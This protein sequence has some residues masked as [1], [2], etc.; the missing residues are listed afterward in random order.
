MKP[1]YKNHLFATPHVNGELNIALLVVLFTRTTTWH[2]VL[3]FLTFTP[4]TE[5][6]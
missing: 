2:D 1:R 6:L 4:E 5:R 3:E